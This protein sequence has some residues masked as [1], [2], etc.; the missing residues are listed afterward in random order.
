MEFYTANMSNR[1][2]REK[3]ITNILDSDGSSEDESDESDDGKKGSRLVNPV[4][5]IR[6]QNTLER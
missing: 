5:Q 4:K 3:F 2:V 6:R 1:E